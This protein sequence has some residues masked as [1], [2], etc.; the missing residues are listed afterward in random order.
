MSRG[1]AADSC[2]LTFCFSV[3]VSFRCM[4]FSQSCCSSR[5]WRMLLVLIA[6]ASISTSG[7]SNSEKKTSASEHYGAVF[8]CLF[9]SSPESATGNLHLRWAGFDCFFGLVPGLVLWSVSNSGPVYLA[10][11]VFRDVGFGWTINRPSFVCRSSRVKR[12]TASKFSGKK[13]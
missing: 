10:S 11:A 5:C 4:R 6:R 8:L 7:F 13:R 2:Y 12:A 1:V 9:P 3:R